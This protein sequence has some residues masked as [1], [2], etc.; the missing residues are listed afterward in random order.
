MLYRL[1]QVSVS[2]FYDWDRRRT[3]P[4]HQ[5]IEDQALTKQVAIIHANC[6]QT[7]GPPRIALDPKDSGPRH[8]RNRMARLRR[9]GGL[10]GG[11]RRR[12]RV[13]TTDSNHDHPIAPNRLTTV[14]AAS[15]PNQVWVAGIT[16]IQTDE[17][18][19]YLI[20]V[21]D[22][23]SRRLVGWTMG[24]SID[25]ALVLSGLSM[26]LRHRSSTPGLIFHSDRGVQY[27][28]THF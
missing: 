24:Y 28:A 15:A 13:Q 27:A 19:L 22:A 26:V 14:P 23:Y 1:L 25:C 2:G 12:Y 21:L 5:A 6:C 7:Y 18:W 20:G 9:N 17:G 16:H 3:S 11:Q 10:F 4:G 8:G